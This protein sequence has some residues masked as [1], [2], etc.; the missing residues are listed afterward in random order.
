MRNSDRFPKGKPN[1]KNSSCAIY[2]ACWTFG[3]SII[4]RPLTWLAGYDDDDEDDDDDDMMMMMMML[5]SL[6]Q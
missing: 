3:V 4:R 5:L 6:F 2:S 1:A